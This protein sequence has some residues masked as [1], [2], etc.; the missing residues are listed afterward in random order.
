MLVQF[1]RFTLSDGSSGVGVLDG[2]SLYQSRVAGDLGSVLRGGLE[3]IHAWCSDCL[4]G[5]AVTSA[6]EV[7]APIDGPTE[8]WGAG[9]TYEASRHA[10]MEESS[11]PSIYSKVYWAERPELFYK[12]AAS[13]AVG[14]GE[15]IRLRDD[16]TNSIPEPE[17]VVVLNGHGEVVGFC[18]GDDVTSRSIEAENPLY[19]PQAKIWSG[20][21]AIG[22]GIVP[23]WEVDDPADLAISMQIR[24]AGVTIFNGQGHTRTMR[25]SI[26]ELTDFLFSNLDF[27]DGVFLMTGTSVVPDLDFSLRSGD[28]VSIEIP[29]LGALENPVM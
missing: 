19:L 16:S 17:L 22:P 10:R 27:P 13:R 6:F 3:E 25:R 2:G 23:A 26:T 28:V 18:V 9:V 15:P 12:S 5:G 20:S 14:P 11:E 4:S 24:R 1:V 21:C 8:V 7:T 29:G